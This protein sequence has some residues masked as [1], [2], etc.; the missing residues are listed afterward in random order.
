[1]K[2]NF[3]RGDTSDKKQMHVVSWYTITKPKEE[4]GLG[5]R[6]L[7]IC[8]RACFMKLVWKLHSNK[9]ELWCNVLRNKYR[10]SNINNHSFKSS[11]S[12]LW[13]DI[14]KTDHMMCNIGNWCVGNG[15]TIQAWTDYWIEPGVIISELDVGI[16]DEIFLAR[17]CDLIIMKVVRTGSGLGS[18]CRMQTAFHDKDY[19]RPLDMSALVHNR[20]QELIAVKEG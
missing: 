7:D 19:R 2:R 8:N 20:V 12:K 9:E 16:P 4:G 10:V 18:G 5:L 13:R 15:E 17:V 1:M 6:K 14:V 3:I 11:Y